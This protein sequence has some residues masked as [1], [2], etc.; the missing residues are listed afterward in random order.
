MWTHEF[1]Q[2]MLIELVVSDS[3]LV[4]GTTALSNTDR[5]SLDS[6]VSGLSEAL[7]VEQRRGRRA[8]HERRCRATAGRPVS[9]ESSE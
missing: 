1:I 9:P 6:V 2:Q 8:F 7:A 4:A 5:A 3:L